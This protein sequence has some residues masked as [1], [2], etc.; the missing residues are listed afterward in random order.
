MAGIF[1]RQLAIL[2]LSPARCSLIVCVLLV[3]SRLR[4]LVVVL[5]LFPHVRVPWDMG[6]Y[7]V[8]PFTERKN[9]GE[10]CFMQLCTGLGRL[11]SR[12]NM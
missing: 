12:R 1:V 8:G 10:R 4:L 9:G 5:C 6:N 7:F 2:D 11:N 3:S